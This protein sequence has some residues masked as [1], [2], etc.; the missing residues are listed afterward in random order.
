MDERDL[1]Q[2]SAIHKG[3]SEPNNK[4]VIWFDTSDP[5]NVLI[6]VWDF[7]ALVWVLLV[8]DEPI[9][10]FEVPAGIFIKK[11]KRV[12]FYGIVSSLTIPIEC[13]PQRVLSF[14]TYGSTSVS[15]PAPVFV[16]FEVNGTTIPSASSGSVNN[17][18]GPITYYLEE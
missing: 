11:G 12:T 8:K 16:V 15:N 3:S 2:I 4:Y 1:G 13:R 9:E 7:D 17:W 5:E 18:R 14:V 6:K 10:T